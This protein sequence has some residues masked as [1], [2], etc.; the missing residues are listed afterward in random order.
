MWKKGRG[1][2]IHF[3]PRRHNSL[4]HSKQV[5]RIINMKK[6]WYYFRCVRG[7]SSRSQAFGLYNMTVH[8]KHS[9][10]FL[11]FLFWGWAAILYEGLDS[12]GIFLRTR[13]SI[14]N[15]LQFKKTQWFR[16]KII[17]G[18]CLVFGWHGRKSGNSE[19]Q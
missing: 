1:R 2:R 17:K 10:F 8:P 6:N 3:F 9:I 12:L 18:F 14:Y 15:I 19:H 16:N 4:H 5:G 7:C 13:V 11:L